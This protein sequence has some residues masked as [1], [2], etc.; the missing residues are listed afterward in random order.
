MEAIAGFIDLTCHAGQV[1][2]LGVPRNA[3]CRMHV[4]AIIIDERNLLSGELR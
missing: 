2:S 3:L 4:G 1:A